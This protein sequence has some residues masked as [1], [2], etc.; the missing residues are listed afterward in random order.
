[1]IF[2]NQSWLA[3][4]GGFMPASGLGRASCPG[5]GPAS[6]PFGGLDLAAPLSLFLQHTL[7]ITCLANQS[8]SI[9]VQAWEMEDTC[10]RR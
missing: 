9:C 1:M 5:G 8:W 3:P 10:S 4:E 6:K 2:K 7:C